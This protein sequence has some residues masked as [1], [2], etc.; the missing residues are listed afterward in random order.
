MVSSTLVPVILCG[1]TGTRLWPLSRATYPKQYWALAGSG[2]ETLLQQTHQR[3]EGLAGLAAPL[4]I[5][6][7][8]HRFIVAEQMRQIGVDPA[9]ILLEPVGRNTAPAVAVAALK[10]TARG[11]DPLLLVLAADHVIQDPARFQSTVEAGM[12]AAEAGQLVTFGIVPTAPEIGY[13]YI[14]AA[15][16]LAGASAPVP[17]AR[18]V[19]KPDRATA[20]QFL[21]TGRFTWNS[22]MFLFKASAILA[23]LE[24]LA[25]DVVSACRSA[26]EHDAADLDFLRLEREA[27]ASCPNVAIDVA[28]MEKTDRGAVL[29]LEAGWSD[30]GSWS[31]LWE[32]AAERD[33]QGNVLRGRVISEGSRNCY[34]RSEHRLVVGLGV[35]DLV[36]VETDDVVLVAHRDR[37]QDVKTVVGQ[38]ESAGAY[39]S[40]AHRKIYRPWGSYDGVTEGGRWQVK[41][42]VVNPGAS[43]SLQMHHHRAE[44][45]IVVAG[46]ALVEKNGVEELVGENQSTYIPLGCRH[47]LTNPGKIPVE[48]IEVQSGPYLGEDDIVRFE[49]RYGRSDQPQ[50]QAIAS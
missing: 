7:E 45:W 14:E 25:P 9:A 35:E 33:E 22:G 18:F 21:A 12:E 43:L 34:L 2:E 28:V 20:E 30:V 42:I 13:G 15:Q 38:L 48:M 47:R 39:E 19:E 27:F 37:A 36:V 29:P 11:E 31:A 4:L 32:T 3:L 49:D 44:H 23:E 41:K 46:T 16:S 6:N 1:G 24:R 10:A 40:K 26:L 50:Q 8:D 17:I 5:C